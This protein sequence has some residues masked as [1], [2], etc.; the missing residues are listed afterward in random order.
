[1]DPQQQTPDMETGSTSFQPEPN[2]ESGQA[3]QESAITWEASEHVH[4]EKDMTWLASVVVVGLVV[5]A[6]S[7][8]VL[9][10]WSFALLVVVMTVAVVVMAYRPP[11]NLRYGLDSSG[12]H[13]EEKYY[14]YGE[15]RSF[16]LQQEGGVYSI[17]ML[18]I[19]RL[20]PAVSVYFPPEHGEQIVD[21]IG[22]RLPMEQIKPDFI[23]RLSKK[24]RF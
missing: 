16:G 10:S 20:M 1:M 11:R 15:F 2:S 4:Y 3:L 18:P 24:I 23:D 6:L 17:V 19:K 8:L 22:S 7:W 14:S 5:A 21:M 9:R 12:I 13:I